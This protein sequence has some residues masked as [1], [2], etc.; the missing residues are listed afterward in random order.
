MIF[1]KL[2]RTTDDAH[3]DA[4]ACRLKIALAT[5][6]SPM[7]L[8]WDLTTEASKFINKVDR[9][10]LSNHARHAR[11]HQVHAVWMPV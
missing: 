9:C 3:P 6:D 8:P 1:R 2:S 10:D 5:M 11:S 4:H 7:G